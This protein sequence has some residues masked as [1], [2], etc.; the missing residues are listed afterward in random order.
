MQSTVDNLK[1]G[2]LRIVANG[3]TGRTDYAGAP[4]VT[5]MPQADGG[6]RFEMRICFDGEPEDYLHG[7]L[8]GRHIRFTRT[9]VKAIIQ[10][11]EGYLFERA[12][13]GGHAEMAGTFSHNGAEGY[14]WYGYTE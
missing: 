8:K 6:Y 10:E 9:R 4:A 2:V 13:P 14:A 3:Y 7:T 12:D 5:W 1:N 11:Y